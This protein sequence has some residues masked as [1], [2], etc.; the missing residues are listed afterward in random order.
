MDTNE[1]SINEVLMQLCTIQNMLVSNKSVMTLKDVASYTGLS[2]SY[3]YKLTM[4]GILPHS[5]PNGKQIYVSKA[6]LDTWLLS[7]G[8]K[9]NEANSVNASSYLTLKKGGV[10]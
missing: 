3:L 8:C 1:N 10:K 2:I 9:N 4:A 6:V 5:K 7:K